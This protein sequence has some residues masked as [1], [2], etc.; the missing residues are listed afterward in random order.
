MG[1]EKGVSGKDDLI[2]TWEL[3]DVEKRALVRFWVVI[4]V[5]PRGK[6]SWD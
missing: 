1:S 5:L 4:P 2:I 3:N 6:F